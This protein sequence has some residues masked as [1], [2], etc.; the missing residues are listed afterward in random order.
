MTINSNLNPKINIQYLP[1]RIFNVPLKNLTSFKEPS[2]IEYS[3]WN[4]K[5]NYK[6]VKAKSKL[7]SFQ[8]LIIRFEDEVVVNFLVTNK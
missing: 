5:I 4:K 3:E 1:M 6:R 2:Q 7:Y 8:R